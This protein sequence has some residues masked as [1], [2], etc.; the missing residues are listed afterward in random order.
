MDKVMFSFPPKPTCVVTAMGQPGLRE[1]V[2]ASHDSK[3]MFPYVFHV[4]A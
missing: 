1:Y 4:R 3:P 2:R